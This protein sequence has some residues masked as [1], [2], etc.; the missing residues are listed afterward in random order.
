MLDSQIYVNNHCIFYMA[1]IGKRIL[2][3]CPKDGYTY[4]LSSWG[5]YITHVNVP[6]I[7]ESCMNNS[8]S[9]EKSSKIVNNRYSQKFMWYSWMYSERSRLENGQKKFKFPVEYKHYLSKLT[10][11]FIKIQIIPPRQLIM[12]CLPSSYAYK[13]KLSKAFFFFFLIQIV[14]GYIH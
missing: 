10:F 8:I 5:S 3:Q 13:L 12:Q 7:W 6:F 2:C 14:W 9:F 4:S 1:I 11:P